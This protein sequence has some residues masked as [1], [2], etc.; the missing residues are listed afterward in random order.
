MMMKINTTEEGEEAEE[1]ADTG[2]T[3]LKVDRTLV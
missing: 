2:R 1:L 3:P